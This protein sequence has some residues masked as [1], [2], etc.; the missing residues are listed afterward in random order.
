MGKIWSDMEHDKNFYRAQV[1]CL[2]WD[3]LQYQ[4]VPLR[5]KLIASKISLKR[6]CILFTDVIQAISKQRSMIIGIIQFSDLDTE[7]AVD[8]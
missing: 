1:I 7:L 3:G 2:R 8:K 5:Q 4:S 6:L